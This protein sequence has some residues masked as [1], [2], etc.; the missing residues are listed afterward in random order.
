MYVD[1]EVSKTSWCLCRHNGLQGTGICVDTEASKT[2]WCLCRHCVYVD[3]V[4]CKVG[5]LVLR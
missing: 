4:A 2:S 3:T 1:T 5:L